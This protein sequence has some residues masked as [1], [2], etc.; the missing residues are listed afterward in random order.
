VITQGGENMGME[1]EHGESLGQSLEGKIINAI[2]PLPKFDV[3]CK[4]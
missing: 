1:F 3:F 4:K 2:Y